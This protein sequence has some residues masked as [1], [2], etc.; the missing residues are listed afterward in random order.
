MVSFLSVDSRPV[1]SVLQRRSHYDQSLRRTKVDCALDECTCE[2]GI[3]VSGAEMAAGQCRAVSRDVAEAIACA[4][5][6][7]ADWLAQGLIRHDRGRCQS[8]GHAR[9]CNP[10]L[11]AECV[12]RSGL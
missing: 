3:K 5:R 7:H 6:E 2:K 12:D 10:V 9:S 8:Q 4:A 11:E 1:C